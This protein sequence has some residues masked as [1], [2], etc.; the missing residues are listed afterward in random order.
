MKPLDLVL[1]IERK[2][3]ARKTLQPFETIKT[4]ATSNDDDASAEKKSK[5]KISVADDTTGTGK[6]MEN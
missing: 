6:E 2:C 4:D 3:F 1:N 5:Y